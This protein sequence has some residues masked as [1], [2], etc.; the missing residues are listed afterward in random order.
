MYNKIIDYLENKHIAILGF[1]MEGK[2]TYRFIRRHSDMNLTLIDK[3]EVYDNNRELLQGDDNVNYVIGSEYLN[4]LDEYDLVIKSPGVITKD[5]DV[6]DIK[7]SSQLEL[8]LKFYR[9]NIIG[10]TGTKGKSTT[11]TLIYEVLKANNMDVRLLGN[12]GIPLLDDV[13]SYEEDTQL[14][15]EMAELQLEYVTYSPHI[16]IV[17]NMF[18][19][20][21]DHSGTLEKYH[22]NILKM[23]EY[24]TNKDYMIYFSDIEPLNSYID[25]KY[26]GR[27][28]RAQLHNQNITSQ[29]AYIYKEMIWLNQKEL[30][31]INTE[32][33][34]IGEHNLRNIMTSLIVSTILELDIKKTVDAIVKF[35]PLKHRIELVGTYDGVTYYDDAIA[36]IPSATM[37][38]VKALKKVDSLIFGG[39]DRGINYDEFVDFLNTGIVRNLICMPTT[40]HKII[41]KVDNNDVNKYNVET[42][43]E[44]VELAATIT[45]KEHICLLS[46][47]AASY[48]FYKNFEEKGTA[49]QNIVKGL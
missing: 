21:L 10:I 5:I 49:Y 26:K 45:E 31:D 20:H 35:K 14:V 22:Q 40:G 1:G 46:P 34:I 39:M 25:D 42:L 41:S 17:L 48:E 2:S 8:L 13:E 37:H 23:F 44:A 24:Q 30:F 33:N 15:I 18:E 9:E 4:N 29:T 36:T 3:D 7:F 12:M 28:Y 27:P 6:S 47:S 11:T 16:G 32:V 38:A 43:E 19:D